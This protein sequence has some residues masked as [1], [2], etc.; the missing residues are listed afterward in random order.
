MRIRKQVANAFL[1]QWGEECNGCNSEVFRVFTLIELLVV[2]AIIAILASMLLPALGMAKAKAK[3]ISCVSNLKQFGTA[4]MAYCDDSEGWFPE[5]RDSPNFQQRWPYLLS[6]YINY[7]WSDRYN[8]G[9]PSIFHCPS[10]KP[11]TDW[12][13]TRTMYSSRGYA[14]NK[15]VTYNNLNN[16]GNLG[17]METPCNT[18]VMMDFWYL[19]IASGANTY[20]KVEGYLFGGTAG[21]YYVHN[22]SSDT[23]IAYRHS[24]RL[25]V[26]FGDGHV[27]SCGRSGKVTAHG[28]YLPS[29]VKFYNKGVVY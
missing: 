2:I 27:L 14:F 7:K 22:S 20:S 3:E 12:V 23:H 16:T 28:I 11:L 18:F 4:N 8:I 19:S 15:S 6:S 13:T 24:K 1:R 21:G 25:N 9:V 10:G 5:T 29:G 17:S 26:L